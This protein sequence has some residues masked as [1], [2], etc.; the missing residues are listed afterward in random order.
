M[1][2]YCDHCRR[3][4]SYR[5]EGGPL[6]CRSVY[7]EGNWL[8]PEAPNLLPEEKN[9]NNDCPHFEDRRQKGGD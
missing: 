3:I 4:G 5:H 6:R 8:N 9:K 1:K 7:N 2:V